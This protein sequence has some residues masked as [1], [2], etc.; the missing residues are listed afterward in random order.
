MFKTIYRH[1]FFRYLFIGVSTFSLDLGLLLLLHGKLQ[2]AVPLATSVAY[3]TSV[4]FNFTLNRK[5]TFSADEAKSLSRHVMLYGL[6]LGINYLFT[7]SF[8][9]LASHHINYAIAKIIAVGL[10][11]LWTYPIYRFVI[12]KSATPT[13]LSMD[14]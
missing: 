2:L 13:S 5:W 8:V 11:V 3:W 9:S 14:L 12:F 10:Q 7:V 4:V 1:H 6:L